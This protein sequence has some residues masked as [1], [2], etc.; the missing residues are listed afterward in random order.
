MYLVRVGS[1]KIGRANLEMGYQKGE[2]LVK[3]IGI[4]YCSLHSSVV[5]VSITNCWHLFLDF[6][7]SVDKVKQL[8]WKVIKNDKSQTMYCFDFIKLL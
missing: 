7:D 3:L 2:D 1:Q 6:S 4:K 8:T 5:V